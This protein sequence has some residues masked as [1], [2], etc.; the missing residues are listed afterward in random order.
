MI[1]F[2][3]K[4][5]KCIELLTDFS[6]KIWSH[7]ITQTPNLR[8]FFLQNKI[9]LGLWGSV[10]TTHSTEILGDSPNTSDLFYFCR[11]LCEFIHVFLSVA[12]KRINKSKSFFLFLIIFCLVSTLIFWDF[13]IP[14][15]L[16]SPLPPP[17]MY[18]WFSRYIA[19]LT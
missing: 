18:T 15:L 1:F 5:R 14:D 19:N 7:G 8:K 2:W 10:R 6:R 4:I 9:K 16:V 13:P 11:K 12:L 3:K 17:K